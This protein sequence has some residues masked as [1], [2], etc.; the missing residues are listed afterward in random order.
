MDPALDQEAISLVTLRLLQSCAPGATV[1]MKTCEFALE[2]F[3]KFSVVLATHSFYYFYF[4]DKRVKIEGLTMMSGYSFDFLSEFGERLGGVITDNLALVKYA[5]TRLDSLAGR[6]HATYA[7]VDPPKQRRNYRDAPMTRRL[8]WASRLDVEKRP[9]LLCAIGRALEAA[10]FKVTIDVFGSA[11]LNQFDT[12]ILRSTP[13]VEYK[14]PFD[15]FYALRPWE[16]D[17]FV[18]TSAYDGSPNV[19]L[20]AMSAGLIVIAPSLGGIPEAVTP[21]SGFLVTPDSEDEHLARAYVERIAQLYS[22][23]YDLAAMSEAAFDC[24]A[25]RHTRDELA[26]RVAGLFA[27]SPTLASA[28]A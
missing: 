20:E 22:G 11:I 28:A 12:A 17:A 3:K 24:I 1:F 13:R 8:L 23:E 10:A 25:T 27:P 14:G 21:K 15:D 4:S 16:Y 6:W 5:S 2:F 19:V 18:Y 26:R 7:P 9:L